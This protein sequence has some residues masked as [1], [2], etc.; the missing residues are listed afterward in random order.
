M[1]SI[2][3]SVLQTNCPNVD[4]VVFAYDA[5]VY[6]QVKSSTKPAG[7]DCVVVNGSPWTTKELYEGKSIFNSHDHYKA[8]FVVL[9]ER[10][11]EE[12]TVFYVAQAEALDR[13]A[14]ERA[15]SFMG[16]PKKDGSQRSI[17]FRKELPRELLKP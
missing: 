7:K 17:K 16:R 11:R 10:H 15:L 5:P 2:V 9:V 6:V 4:L 12:G 13:M 14:R 3:H 1:Q 8:K